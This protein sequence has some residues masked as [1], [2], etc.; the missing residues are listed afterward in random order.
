LRKRKPDLHKGDCGHVLVIGGS[1]GLTGAACLSAE[2]ALRAG[3][4][5]VTVGVPQSLNSIFEIKLTEAMSLPLADSQGSLSLKAFG[6]IKHFLNKVDVILLG[7]GASR[8][9][10]TERL[11][12]KIVKEVNKPMVVDADALNAL[13]GNLKVL[14]K[15]KAKQIV[16]TPHLG[17]FSRLTNTGKEEIKKTKRELVKKFAFRYNL[18]LV[19]KGHRTLITDGRKVYENHTGNSGMATAGMGDVLAGMIAGMIAQGVSCLEA[20]RFGVYLHGLSGDLAGKQKT[21]ICLLA[22]DL[23]EYLPEAVKKVRK[24]SPA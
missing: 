6:Q 15:R 4:G 18:I 1:S 9:S 21:D 7:P 11:I 3:A 23:I 16:L 19:L 5:L 13:S 14:D 20:A 8:L 12:V 24:S 10:D 2:A 22:S 17:E